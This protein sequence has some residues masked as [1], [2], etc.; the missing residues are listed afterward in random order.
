LEPA[1]RH[2]VTIKDE[3]GELS[4]FFLD[5]DFIPQEFFIIKD[6][7]L[8]ALRG[9]HAH[10]KCKQLIMLI[11][12]KLNVSLESKISNKTVLL[13]N[14]GSFIVIPALTWSKQEYL[15][16][17]TEIIVFCSEEFDEKDYIRDYQYF[18]KLI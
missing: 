15:S 2:S 6:V 10:F 3:R 14:P 11:K 7:P 4:K 1:L 16:I 5:I 13:N 8:G 12:G 9:Q 17:N 18:K